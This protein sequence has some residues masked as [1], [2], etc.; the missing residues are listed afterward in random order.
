M[1]KDGPLKDG[2]LKPG[3]IGTDDFEYPM[4]KDGPLK[5]AVERRFVER[6][7]VERRT[8][9][10]LAS[11]MKEDRD[12]A[13]LEKLVLG[14]HEANQ[15]Q[16]E[17][18]LLLRQ[19]LCETTAMASQAQKGLHSMTLGTASEPVVMSDTSVHSASND[20]S[21]HRM[22][23]NESSQ[24]AMI[25]ARTPTSPSQLNH[26]KSNGSVYSMPDPYHCPV[27]KLEHGRVLSWGVGFTGKRKL[28]AYNFDNLQAYAALPKL[29]SPASIFVLRRSLVLQLLAQPFI[30][31]G[32]FVLTRY[33]TA[34]L[35]ADDLL[36]VVSPLVNLTDALTRLVP[37]LLGLFIALMLK[38][39]WALRSNFLQ[40]VFLAASQFSL[41]LGVVL[42]Q[43]ARQFRDRVERYFMLAH[44]MIYICA[45]Q[46]QHTL[47]E[48]VEE[49][50][51]T[52]K[53]LEHIQRTCEELPHSLPTQVGACDM[54]SAGIPLTW[55]TQMIIRLNAF[56]QTPAGKD[57]GFAIS[58]PLMVKLIGCC[59]DAR[60]GI[61]EIEMMLT[62]PLPFPY[63]HLV[64]CL[65]HLSAMFGCFKSGVLLAT[66][67]SDINFG[68]IVTEMLFLLSMNALYSGLLCLAVVLTNPFADDCVDFPAANFQCRLW[69][70][71]LF[72][73]V[74]LF[75]TD[76]VDA[77]VARYLAG[78]RNPSQS[79]GG[80]RKKDKEVDDEDDEE[81]DDE[82]EDDV[83]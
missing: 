52:R 31:A 26:G 37:F 3:R 65:V 17:S 53:E 62:S 38:R 33:A 32:I 57:A 30:T 21:V 83:P 19:L 63:V 8:V 71:Q 35:D 12:A 72:S 82:D 24:Q 40:R 70:S 58:P 60:R 75:E 14:Q 56:S 16:R 80:F 44:K 22:M 4:L 42:P 64:T 55:A 5:E 77:S 69:K 48:L 36:A 27:L 10:R 9:E 18:N 76:Q 45:R 1:L 11:S 78:Y 15:L 61:Q 46:K 51:L 67:G 74:F 54:S 49:G 41:V 20:C 59:A 28:L 25:A 68:G 39:W 73:R 13:S 2:P 34:G 6:E 79:L 23:S 81:E 29:F 50:M 66:A 43:E 7:A 47:P